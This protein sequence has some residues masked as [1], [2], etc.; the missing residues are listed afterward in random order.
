MTRS[1]DNES[2][3]RRGAAGIGVQQSLISEASAGVQLAGYKESVVANNQS[4]SPARA[5]LAFVLGCLAGLLGSMSSLYLDPASGLVLQLT[6]AVFTTFLVGWISARVSSSHLAYLGA[7]ILLGIGLGFGVDALFVHRLFHGGERNL[8]P[9][10]LGFFE[11][12]GLIPCA[13]GLWVGRST[14]RRRRFR[15]RR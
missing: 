3:R 12:V 11:A 8:W 4:G 6:A 10:E 2:N 5:Y 15:D 7:M 1:D 13:A 14:L 9:L